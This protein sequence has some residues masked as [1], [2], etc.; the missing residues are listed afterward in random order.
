MLNTPYISIEAFTNIQGT[1][2]HHR[3]KTD[4][5]ATA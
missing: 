2:K 5:I 4:Q 1:Q 3:N